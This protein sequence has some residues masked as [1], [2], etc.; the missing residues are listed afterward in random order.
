[1]GF[2]F[3]KRP[4]Q[5]GKLSLSLCRLPAGTAARR[6]STTIIIKNGKIVVINKLTDHL[7]R[8][9]IRE[10]KFDEECNG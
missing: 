5:A 7:K 1:M 6:A 3:E 4:F 2:D 9:E 10:I 8:V